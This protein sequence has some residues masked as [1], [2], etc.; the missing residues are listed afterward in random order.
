MKRKLGIVSVILASALFGA[1]AAAEGPPTTTAEQ[2][3]T[4][5]NNLI[6]DCNR[7]YGDDASRKA[8]YAG[9]NIVL[10][11]CI[12]QVYPPVHQPR[13]PGDFNGDG[14]VDPF[15]YIDA[16]GALDAGELDALDF[17]D[18]LSAYVAG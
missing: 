7:R 17:V 10:T 9:A 16:L 3:W 2:C 12:G 1:A 18:F 6:A 5:F 14:E 15:D 4:T 8:C 13:P 11:A